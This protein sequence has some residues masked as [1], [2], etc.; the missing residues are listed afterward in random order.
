[1]GRWLADVD[2]ARDYLAGPGGTSSDGNPSVVA[3]VLDY[4]SGEGFGETMERY[5]LSQFTTARA[6]RERYIIQ[7]LRNLA[8]R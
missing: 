5:G 1:M 8:G 2:R 3:S 6:Y 4:A 7:A